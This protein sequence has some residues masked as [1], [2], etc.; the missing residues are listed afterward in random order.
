MT[1][2]GSSA[3]DSASSDD[4][5]IV[6]CLSQRAEKKGL[7]FRGLETTIRDTLDWQ[8]T[9]PAERQQTLRAGLSLDAEKELLAKL[10][11]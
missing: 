7:T 6:R 4:S 3:A 2:E 11:A 10:R 8:Q 1:R 5:G 9:R